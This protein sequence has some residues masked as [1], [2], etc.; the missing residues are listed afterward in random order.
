MVSFPLPTYLPDTDIFL[1]QKA[2][3]ATATAG[4]GNM[5]AAG[6]GGI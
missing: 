5:E 2:A 6:E 3:A 4:G 1:Q